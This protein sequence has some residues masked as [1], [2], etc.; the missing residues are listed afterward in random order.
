V[1]VREF[2]SSVADQ[3]PSAWQATTGPAPEL[4][5]VSATADDLWKVAADAKPNQQNQED[6]DEP[7]VLH[8]PL[9]VGMRHNMP[10]IEAGGTRCGVSLAPPRHE[11][12]RHGPFD[13][14]AKTTLYVLVIVVAWNRVIT[15]L[16]CL[17]PVPFRGAK[18][19]RNAGAKDLVAKLP[20][21]V[22]HS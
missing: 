13:D 3:T 9:G 1:V 18:G 2:V 20:I 6:K 19:I 12:P 22:T 15:V 14:G 7:K 17:T 4:L 11:I 5:A 16:R 8:L 10:V 21:L